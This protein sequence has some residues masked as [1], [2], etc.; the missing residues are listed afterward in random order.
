MFSQVILLLLQKFVGNLQMI[1]HFLLQ[2]RPILLNG[3]AQETD[4]IGCQ[5]L[6]LSLD[7]FE[8]GYIQF[9][10]KSLLSGFTLD[11]ITE[12]L[13]HYIVRLDNTQPVLGGG[14]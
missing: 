2:P 14:M 3:P 6:S 13:P 8:L 4:L 11:H 9:V 12:R 1:I 5:I 7:A 10:A